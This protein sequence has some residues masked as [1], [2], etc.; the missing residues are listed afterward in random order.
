MGYK[1]VSVK[2]EVFGRKK[3]E[4]P[5]IKPVFLPLSLA[6]NRKLMYN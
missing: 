1:V 6:I 5:R 2:K 4:L 3:R